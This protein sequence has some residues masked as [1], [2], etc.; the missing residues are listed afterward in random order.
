MKTKILIVSLILI[1][2]LAF[3]QEYYIFENKKQI[4]NESEL[5]KKIEYL[6]L[7]L[8]EKPT[9]KKT[10]HVIVGY[11]IIDTYK[12]GDSII[13]KIRHD[14]KYESTRNEKIYSFES[15]NLPEFNLKNLKSDKISSN[16]LKGK[17]TFINLWFTNCFPCVKEIPLLN[18]LQKKFE[19]EVRFLAITFD[20]KEKVKGFLKKKD[21]NYE[22]LVN[23]KSYLKNDL[24]NIAYPKI[25]ILDKNGIVKYLGEGI[26]SEY[27]YEKR[28]M[29]DRTE[30][31]LVYLEKILKDLI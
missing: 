18:I 30:K 13:N 12:R 29:K 19:N 8:K 27:D 2:S 22:H 25:I 10:L 15:K 16:N 28:K 21:F 20:S 3:S 23:A 1:N 9:K 5:K 17:V 6:N 4:L 14:F 26:P 24:G 11:K 31:D 7:K